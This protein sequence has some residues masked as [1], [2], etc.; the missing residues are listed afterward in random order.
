MAD[1]AMIDLTEDPAG[2]ATA[3]A[4][5]CT[6]AY[7]FVRNMVMRPAIKSCHQRINDL[8]EDRKADRKRIADLELTLFNHGNG[9]MRAAM[10]GAVSELHV[11]LSKIAAKLE[12]KP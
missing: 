11:D 2:R 9:D 1:P 3:F 5:G 8:E 12:P 10:Q 7:V 4:A 6:A